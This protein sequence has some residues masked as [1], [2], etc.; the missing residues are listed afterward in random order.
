MTKFSNELKK[1]QHISGPFSPYLG[2]KYFFKKS[3]SVMHNTKWTPKHHDEF[4]KKLM[5]QSQE[6]FCTKGRKDRMMGRS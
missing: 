4:Q 3:G 1:Q 2:Q 5:S 6:N